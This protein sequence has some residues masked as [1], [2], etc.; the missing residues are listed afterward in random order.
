MDL[1]DEYSEFLDNNILNRNL[2]EDYQVYRKVSVNRIYLSWLYIVT[3][4]FFIDMDSS[5]NI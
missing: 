4:L 1:R 3:F 2:F 5:I